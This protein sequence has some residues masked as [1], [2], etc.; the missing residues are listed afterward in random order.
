MK[1]LWIIALTFSLFG[2]FQTTQAQVTA[3]IQSKTNGSI[4][5]NAVRVNFLEI[6]L[7]NIGSQSTAIES[8]TIK[9]SGLST[10][11]DFGRL[12][13]ETADYRRS[14]ARQLGNDDHVRLEFR[15]PYALQPN[16]S[17][18]LNLLGNMEAQNSN[19]TFAFDVVE[20]RTNNGVEVQPVQ[21]GNT[22]ALSPNQIQNQIPDQS[23]QSINQALNSNLKPTSQPLYPNYSTKAEPKRIRYDRDNYQIVC[24]NSV[25][26]LV[27]R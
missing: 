18:V 21:S 23:K 25:C 17:A 16:T 11:E 15:I 5:R 6:Y 13:L 7:K 20:I 27:R 12:W 1:S 9:R 24:R 4:P 10:N 22:Q 3:Q 2:V 8:V 19:R 26:R 14:F